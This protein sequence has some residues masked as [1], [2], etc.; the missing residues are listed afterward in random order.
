MVE[1]ITI[2]ALVVLGATSIGGWVYTIRKNG[3][4]EGRMQQHIANIAEAVGKLPC[5]ADADFLQSIGGLANAVKNLE[6][7]LSRVEGEQGTIH[8]RID[9]IVNG[10]RKR[11]K[12]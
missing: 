3:R 10:R 2:V 12:S 1:V 8:K 6:S 4:T 11:S 5:Q 9:G 7:W